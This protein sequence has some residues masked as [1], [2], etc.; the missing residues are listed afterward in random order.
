MAFAATPG[1]SPASSA[2]STDLNLTAYTTGAWILKKPAE[3]DDAWSAFWL[4]DERAESGWATPQ[5]VVTPQQVLI[6]LAERSLIRALE[7]DSGHTDGD[8]AGSRSAK[9]MV[10]EVSDAGPTTGFAPIASVSLKPKAD[11]QRFVIAKPL[12]GRWLRLTIKNNHGSAEYIELMDFRAFGTQLTKAPPPALT[13][14]YRTNYGNFHLQQDGATVTGC[15]EP[16]EGLVVNGGLEGRV[17]RFTWV[18]P[19]RRGP[20]VL[21][22]SP[23]GKEMLG[24]WWREG[25]TSSAGQIWSGQKTSDAVGACPHWKPQRGGTSQLAGELT[26]AGRARIYGIN[27]DTD[28]D[29]IK[30]ESKAAIEGI[31]ALAKD[32]SDWTFM[33]EGHTD[34]T[35]TARAQ[36]VLVGE[37]RC[38][39]EGATGGRRRGT[40]AA[41]D[42]GLRCQ[43]AGGRQRLGHRAVAEPA[44]GNW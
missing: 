24:L 16:A 10:V 21:A 34:A 41:R 27:F 5:G 23:D 9:D 42:Q 33:I 25:D 11:K 8:S 1:P 15:Y 28:S 18:E 13:G 40:R 36:P 20:A 43:S 12:P 30:P 26:K 2:A 17:T 35:S 14:I 32:K 4:L 38:R 29:A 37:A 31:V 7:F 44:R 39:R 3:Y 22:F 19:T 6:V